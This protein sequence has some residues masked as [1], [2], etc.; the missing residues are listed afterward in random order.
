MTPEE[1][2]AAVIVQRGHLADTLDD[3]TAEQWN[4]DSLCHGW[5][6]RD[7]V[8]HLLS[9][10]EIPMPTF[11]LNVVRARSFDKYA[12]RAAREL[13]AADPASLAERYRVKVNARF[14]PPM[15]GPIAPLSDVCA[16]MRDIGRPLGLPN[17]I[18]PASQKV[19]LGYLCGGKARGFV[20]PSRTKGLRF[21]AT[22]FEWSVGEGQSVRGPG[23]SLMLAAVGRRVALSELTGEG[24]AILAG[25][26]G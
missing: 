17:N 5:K 13:G 9:I 24:V 21:E 16:H 15:V 11:M 26:L 10:L 14:A 22:D 18:D 7:V 2:Y 23:E 1:L 4:I 20:N 3:L 6:V 12:D 19:V 8:G 25:R